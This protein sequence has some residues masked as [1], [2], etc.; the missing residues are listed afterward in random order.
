MMRQ[1]KKDAEIMRVINK[2]LADFLQTDVLEK[3]VFFSEHAPTLCVL[4]KPGGLES[5]DKY[6]KEYARFLA[7]PE[8]YAWLHNSLYF[9][10]TIPMRRKFIVEWLD[11]IPE[12]FDFSTIEREYYQWLLN[13]DFCGVAHFLENDEQKYFLRQLNAMHHRELENSS[14]IDTQWQN[15][16]SAMD[17]LTASSESE[18]V[19]LLGQ[20]CTKLLDVD[21]YTINQLQSS[22]IDLK[23]DEILRDTQVR[24]PDE[25]YEIYQAFCNAFVPPPHS[26]Q[27]INLQDLFR[28]TNPQHSVIL[29]NYQ[30]LVAQAREKAALAC[31]DFFY[32]YYQRSERQ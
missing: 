3:D 2:R 13:N 23:T 5:A 10:L 7:L 6:H 14:D 30:L 20:A 17:V 28:T 8:M 22:L 31:A 19:F 27:P 29:E 24:W 16:I 9:A 26:D 12:G 4:G 11:S 32:T 18:R 1:F 25:A 15:I 21:I